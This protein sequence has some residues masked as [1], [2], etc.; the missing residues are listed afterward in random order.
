M[1]QPRRGPSLKMLVDLGGK[2]LDQ[3]LLSR[4]GLD[5]PLE[6]G[7]RNGGFG[8][9]RGDGS[10]SD[11]SRS[12]G[13]RGV[14]R[15]TGRRPRLAE[16]AGQTNAC[17]VSFA[18]A[19]VALDLGVPVLTIR[20]RRGTAAPAPFVHYLSPLISFFFLSGERGEN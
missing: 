12:R 2:I 16:G 13:D 20:V 9:G 5:Q 17:H 1:V 18:A 3:L 19:V 10:G 7:G 11:R 4:H 15:G 14:D 8:G 6:L